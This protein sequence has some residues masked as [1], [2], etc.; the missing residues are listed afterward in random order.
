MLLCDAPYETLEL[1]YDTF[2][3]KMRIF[4]NI[5]GFPQFW[6]TLYINKNYLYSILLEETIHDTIMIKK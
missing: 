3:F 5:K 2:F 1:L 6:Q 4:R